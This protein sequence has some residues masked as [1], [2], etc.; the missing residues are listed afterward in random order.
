MKPTYRVA[1]I[2][3]GRWWAIEVPALPG[4]HSQARRLDQVEDMAREAIALMQNVPE[5]SF[6]VTVETDLASLGGLQPLINEALEAR[7]AYEL[8]QDR[9]SA[10]MRQAVGEIRSSGYTSRDAGMLLGVSNQRISQIER[11]AWERR[12]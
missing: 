2:R 5:D 12:P 8:A 7:E 11:Q 9:A 10:A 6:D 3:S 4:V 1:A